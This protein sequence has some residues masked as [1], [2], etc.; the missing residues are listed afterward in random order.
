MP[1]KKAVKPS[2]V[3]TPFFINARDRKPI[4]VLYYTIDRKPKKPP[5]PD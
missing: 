2:I 4:F 3:F 1:E 5:K